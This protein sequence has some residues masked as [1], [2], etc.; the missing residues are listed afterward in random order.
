MTKT[1]NSISK[2]EDTKKNKERKKA[3]EWYEYANNFNNNKKNIFTDIIKLRKEYDLMDM[4]VPALYE[5]NERGELEPVYHDVL[6]E[7]G[8]K[9]V[10]RAEVPYVEELAYML[11]VLEDNIFHWAENYEDFYR[12]MARLAMKQK[13]MLQKKGL[14]KEMDPR[15]AMYLLNVKH[16]MI[17]RKRNEVTGK[18]GGA[19]QAEVK[20]EVFKD[21]NE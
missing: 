12:V 1:K 2:I 18:D 3:L 16:D 13:L 5:E 11:G 8:M 20:F 7:F 14:T 17:E 10:N 21:D 9:Y 6:A 4:N 19:I 15:M